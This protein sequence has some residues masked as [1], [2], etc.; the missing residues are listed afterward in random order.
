[1]SSQKRLVEL[2]LRAGDRVSSMKMFEFGIT[3]LSAIIYKLRNEGLNIKGENKTCKNRYGNHCTYTEYYLEE[4][5]KE[6]E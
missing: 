4:G 2:M 5:E 1:M 6:H 3:R